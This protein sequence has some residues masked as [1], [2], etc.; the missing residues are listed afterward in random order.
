MRHLLN[1]VKPALILLALF[2]ALTGAAYPA[3]VTGTAQLLFPDQ[4]NGSLIKDGDQVVGSALI[5]QQFSDPRDFWGRPSATGPMPYNGG[6]SGGSN[7]GPLNPALAEA[8]KARIAVL[9]ESNPTQ[10]A[11]IPVDLVTASGSGLDPHL[12][13]AAAHWQV[14]RVA[15]ARHLPDAR[16]RALVEQ[17]TEYRQ[18]GLLGEPRVNVLRLN[19]ALATLQP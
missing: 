4:A 15:A 13:P 1:E 18:F 11:P 2:T 17:Y 14:P 5:G 9:K 12:S 19:R 10:Q 7:L 6:A 16:V 8:V 3:L